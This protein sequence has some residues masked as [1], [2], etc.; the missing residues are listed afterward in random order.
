MW[1]ALLEDLLALPDISV[2]TVILNR[3]QHHAPTSPQLH[4]R[5][6]TDST[7]ALVHWQRLLHEVDA[8]WIIAPESDGLLEQLVTTAITPGVVSCNA[9]PEAIRLCSD[10]LALSRHLSRHGIITLPTEEETWQTPPR[11]DRGFFVVKPRDGVGSH[12]VRRIDSLTDW[13]R[14][15]EEFLTTGVSSAIRQ[16]FIDGQ[17]I[18]IAAWLHQH[19]VTW[20][21]V[22]EQRLSTDG[23]FTYLG[24]RLPAEIDPADGAAVRQLAADAAATIPG[25]FGYIGFDILLPVASPTQ[26]VLVEINPRLTTS[27]IGLRR[28]SQGNWLTVMLETPPQWH[29]DRHIE[30]TATGDVREILH[31]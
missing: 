1:R 3:W 28:L 25:L 22:A 15:R 2:E 7:N 20:F 16:P 26:P 11:F 6:V 27:V 9:T 5:H 4:C 8:T 14:A 17:A 30:F 24:G 10:K 18:S 29:E 21:P 23:S 31:L 12:L 13:Q 19:S